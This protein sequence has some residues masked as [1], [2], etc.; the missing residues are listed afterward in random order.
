MKDPE[1]DESIDR[2]VRELMSAEPRP[3]MR[4]RVL[5]RLESRQVRWLTV[6]RLAGS[7]ALASAVLVVFV[8]AGRG[9]ETPPGDGSA[10]LRPPLTRLEHVP[11]AVVPIVAERTMPPGPARGTQPALSVP[12]VFAAVAPDPPPAERVEAIP[13][14][15]PIL[16]LAVARLET[17]GIAMREFGVL[18]LTIDEL[19][20]EPLSPPR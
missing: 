1:L 8:L 16:P 13:A 20:I 15:E 17:E 3:G 10:A 5:A 19:Q 2:A 9:P 14:L 6:R 11:G 12:D 7:L 4:H 18:P